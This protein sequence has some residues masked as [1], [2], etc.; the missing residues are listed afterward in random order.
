[1]MN[2]EDLIGNN[3]FSFLSC[4][5]SRFA[6]LHTTEAFQKYTSIMN[7]IPDEIIDSIRLLKDQSRIFDDEFVFSNVKRT[8]FK[9][10]GNRYVIDVIKLRL[11]ERINN[12][13]A[14]NTPNLQ[15]IKNKNVKIIEV[16]DS[17]DNKVFIV[18]DKRLNA[19]FVT[20]RGTA[21]YKGM[22]SWLNFIRDVPTSHCEGSNGK[23]L[24]GILKL[25]VELIHT[26]Y[27][28][29]CY[30]SNT[31]MNSTNN[32][33]IKIFTTGHSLGGGL[34]TIFAYLW[35]GIRNENIDNVASKIS[36]KI[37]CVSVAS[38]KVINDYLAKNDYYSL[39]DVNKII[40]KRIVTI[41]DPFTT[42]P[43]YLSH[44]INNN[45]YLYCSQ[46]NYNNNKKINYNENLI[47]ENTKMNNY[48]SASLLPHGNYMYISFFN[49]LDFRVKD[50]SSSEYKDS[51][52][53]LFISYT[54]NNTNVNVYKIVHFFLN[55]VRKGLSRELYKAKRNIF[56]F[57]VT[58][59]EDL[60]MNFQL[61]N[62][63][64]RNA[65]DYKKYLNEIEINKERNET[66][67]TNPYISKYRPILKLI[68]NGKQPKSFICITSK[69]IKKIL[70]NTTRRNKPIMTNNF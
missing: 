65:Q 14:A 40:Y 29:I 5:M 48:T 51:I 69:N 7:T 18:A 16:S 41:G 44:P 46:T 49:L 3:F 59:K 11:P 30:L 53:K 50:V 15:K 13:I 38:P 61:Y 6:Y 35:V 8:Y 9:K 33:S 52:V 34:T 12:I 19:I 47:C 27:Y 1:M 21:G 45:S 70:K 37:V 55:D 42:Q 32:D 24:T 43:T 60:Y 57:T 2:N 26:I 25:C 58:H 62:Y 63:I 4:V 66:E 36:D 68:F 28:S 17:N 67:K 54:N 20:F 10:I 64:I 31:F 23:F 56:L 22:T 39:I